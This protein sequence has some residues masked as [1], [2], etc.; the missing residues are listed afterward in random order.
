MDDHLLTAIFEAGLLQFGQFKNGA[1]FDPFRENLHLLPAYPDI[2]TAV[3]DAL[4]PIA[5][6]LPI[7]RLVSVGGALPLGTALSLKTHM[8][9]VY[10]KGSDEPLVN[11]L[12]GAYDVGHPALLVTNVLTR[13]NDSI[14]RLLQNGRRVGLEISHVITILQ[15]GN[16]VLLDDVTLHTLF[17]LDG[18]VA[19]YAARGLIP[20]GQAGAVQNWLI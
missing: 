13:D 3:T 6:S 2:L 18:I 5:Q 4:V 20:Q 10:S 7:E 19:Q 16:P 8:P 9:L 15:I 12:I 1:R 11:D 14:V 17:T